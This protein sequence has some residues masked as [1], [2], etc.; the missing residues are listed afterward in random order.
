ME[1]TIDMVR[2]RIEFGLYLIG[3]ESHPFP[4]R[5]VSKELTHA[6]QQQL[7]W[8]SHLNPDRLPTV[9]MMIT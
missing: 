6:F 8:R 5:R 9:I 1:M 4:S 2:D 7:F 3:F